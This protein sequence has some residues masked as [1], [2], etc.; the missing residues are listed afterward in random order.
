MIGRLYSATIGQENQTT[1]KTLIEIAAASDL[2]VTLERMWISQSDFDTSENLAAKVEDV[3]TTGTGSPFTTPVPL[4]TGDVASSCTVKTDFSIEPIYS[5]LVYI[6]QGFNVL[7]GWLWTPANDDEVI[8]V[9]PTQIAG[10]ALDVAP[11]GS[12]AFSYGLIFR[13]IGG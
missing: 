1:A 2:I 9:S 13:E 7:S 12:M 6:E 3:T 10:I 4:V 8:V 11:S 5:G